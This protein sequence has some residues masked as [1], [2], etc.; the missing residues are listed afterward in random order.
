[1]VVWS[2]VSQRRR[3]AVLSARLLAVRGRWEYADGVGHVIASDLHDL[4][5]LLGGLQTGSRDFH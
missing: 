1:M 2:H 3:K 4:S 5:P